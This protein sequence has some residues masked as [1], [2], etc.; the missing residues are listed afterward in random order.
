MT[1]P[2]TLV[3]FFT[4]AAGLVLAAAC[5]VAVVV[6][7]RS[8]VLGVL[9][10]VALTL[11]VFGFG[12]TM[13][14]AVARVSP[15]LSLLVALLTYALQLLVLLLVLAALEGSTLLEDTVD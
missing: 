14:A 11:V 7:G 5:L 1:E 12:M 9:T 10:G 2:R 15:A 4:S 3:R 8:G 6:D 13:T